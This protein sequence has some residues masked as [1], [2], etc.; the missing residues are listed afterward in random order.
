MF[1]IGKGAALSKFQKFLLFLNKDASK[2]KVKGA[3]ERL[4]P[5]FYDD[6]VGHPFDQTCVSQFH[7]KTPQ[8]ERW[9][10]QYIYTKHQMLQ[11]STHIGYIVKCN[12]AIE[13]IVLNANIGVRKKR[14]ENCFLY[15]LGQNVST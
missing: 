12:V 9:C 11:F 8:I 14:M 2:A 13:E 10:S 6:K 15:N 5:S 7:Q 3:A 4:L 1:P